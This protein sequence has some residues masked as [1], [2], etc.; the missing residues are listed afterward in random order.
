MKLIEY[1]NNTLIDFYK[2]NG[3]EFTKEHNYFGYYR[4]Q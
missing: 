4:K 2:I 1:G 3:L